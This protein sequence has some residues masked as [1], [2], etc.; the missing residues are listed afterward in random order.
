MNT[1]LEALEAKLDDLEHVKKG[2]DSR[3][4]EAE[5][6]LETAILRIA[7]NETAI[8]QVEQAIELVSSN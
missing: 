6:A 3:M 7:Q 2:L 8:G 1:A 5:S 4:K